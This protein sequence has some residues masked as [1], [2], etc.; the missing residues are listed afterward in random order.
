[1]NILEIKNLSFSYGKKS[2]FKDISL[3]AESKSITAIL[4]PNGTGKTTLFH[5]LLGLYKP[6]EGKA[7]IDKTNIFALKPNHRA[8][9]LSYVPQEWQSPFNYNVLDVVIMGGVHKTGLFST[10]KDSFKTLA[11]NLM[12]EIGI[13]ELK[14]AGINELSGGQRQMVL[15][16]RALIQDSPILLL[17]EP[18]SHLD[19]KNQTLLFRQLKNQVEKRSLCVLI[20]IHDPNLVSAYADKVYMI[21]KTKVF[22]S[23]GIKETIN[24]TNLSD[25]YDI[26]IEV[27]SLND[28]LFVYS[29]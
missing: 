10:P 24:K 9:Y 4:G 6:C 23:G 21:K 28:R 13:L 17:D 14:N 12:E 1:M 22:S 26:N 3:S 27:E 5:I 29:V 15:L 11:L 19:I 8:K 2:I 7:Y 20:N 25:L 16:T 18:T